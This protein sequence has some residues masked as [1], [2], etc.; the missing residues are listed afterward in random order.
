LVSLIEPA[1]IV[2]LGVG[3]GILLVSILMPI[4]NVAGGIS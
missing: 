2:G 4:Y 1:M 3:V